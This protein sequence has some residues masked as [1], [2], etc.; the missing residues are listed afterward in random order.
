MAQVAHEIER[1]CVNGDAG[2]HR[3]SAGEEVWALLAVAGEVDEDAPH[4]TR[5]AGRHGEQ[6]PSGVHGGA[7]PLADGPACRDASWWEAA[8][9]VDEQLV[10]EM[11]HDP[12]L[13]ASAFARA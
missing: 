12:S 13:C 10:Q 2:V 4:G 8:E 7:P 6:H 1:A 3:R 5:R 9:D 11:I